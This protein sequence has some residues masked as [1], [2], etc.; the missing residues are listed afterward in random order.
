[1]KLKD[2]A[3]LFSSGLLEG[4]ILSSMSNFAFEVFVTHSLNGYLTLLFIIFLLLASFWI[5]PSFIEGNLRTQ[6]IRVILLGISIASFVMFAFNL[7]VF[8]RRSQF[9]GWVIVTY[10]GPPYIGIMGVPF[11]TIIWSL[12][13][14]SFFTALERILKVWEEHKK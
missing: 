9:G 3:S 5:V 7:I 6:K 11:P 4:I 12:F 2:F 13:L 1:M 8:S 14:G 10:E